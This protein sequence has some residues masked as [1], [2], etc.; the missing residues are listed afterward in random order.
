MLIVYFQNLYS[1]SSVFLHVIVGCKHSHFEHA[2][3]DTHVLNCKT[4][5]NIQVRPR[6]FMAVCNVCTWRQGLGVGFSWKRMQIH[7]NLLYFYVMTR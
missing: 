1:I 3:T 6:V 5:L 7:G 2:K 4:R